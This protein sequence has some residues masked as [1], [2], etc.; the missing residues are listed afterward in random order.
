MIECICEELEE[1]WGSGYNQ[2]TTREI[3]KDFMKQQVKIA[4]AFGWNTL[5]FINLLL[6]HGCVDCILG[7]VGFFV[8]FCFY[9]YV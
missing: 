9:F 4:Q 6:L 3:L 5:N 8:L 1:K 2:N 7:K